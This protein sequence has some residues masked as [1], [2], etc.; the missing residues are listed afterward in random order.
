MQYYFES[1][2]VYQEGSQVCHRR[3]TCCPALMWQTHGLAFQQHQLWDLSSDVG[4]ST[5]V[6]IAWSCNLVDLLFHFHCRVKYHTNVL[7]SLL[8]IVHSPPFSYF[9]LQSPHHQDHMTHSGSICISVLLCNVFGVRL[10]SKWT[11][12]R[13]LGKSCC[14]GNSDRWQNWCTLIVLVPKIWFQP[15]SCTACD[16]KVFL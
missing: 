10:E 3:G 5:D 16:A 11:N 15:S 9:P 13:S 2:A 12:D 1:A 8:Q 6:N 14:K 7:V 4:D